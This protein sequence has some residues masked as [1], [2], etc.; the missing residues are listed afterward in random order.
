[1]TIPSEKFELGQAPY[2]SQPLPSLILPGEH[3]VRQ[4]VTPSDQP[5]RVVAQDYK[6][7]IRSNDYLYAVKCATFRMSK[8]N[9][10][11]QK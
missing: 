3:H 2:N 1:M 8:T 10:F 5:Y 7:P 4:D 9:D 11:T 6:R